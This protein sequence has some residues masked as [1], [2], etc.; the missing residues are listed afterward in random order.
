M[1]CACYACPVVPALAAL[2]KQDQK[3]FIEELGEKDNP[4]L[5]PPLD[6][7][8]ALP[9]LPATH[10]AI[11]EFVV[12]PKQAQKEFTE[13]D[14]AGLELEEGVNSSPSTLMRPLKSP[15]VDMPPYYQPFRR[16]LSSGRVKPY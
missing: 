5:L 12:L 14:A 6:S 1:P 16:D 9:F 11:P 15:W 7:I 10:P 13:E 2:P 8:N 3:E 4:H